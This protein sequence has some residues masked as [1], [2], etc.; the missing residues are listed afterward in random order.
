MSNQERKDNLPQLIKRAELT[1]NEL[2][3]RHNVPSFTFA[4]ESEFAMQALRANDYLAGVACKNQDSLKDA[5]I[6]VAAVGLS[7]SPVFKFAYLV[8][9]K[10]KVCLDISYT[11]LVELATAKGIILWC[12]AEIVYDTDV[13]DFKGVNELP[14]HHYDPFGERGKIIGGYVAAK[15]ANKDLL[16]DFMSI[17]EIHALRDRTESWKAHVKEG[18]STPWATDPHE[19]IKKTLIRRG[20]KSW[21][22]SFAHD[23]LAKAVSVSDEADGIDFNAPQ[24]TP[25]PKSQHREDGLEI[26]RGLLAEIGRTEEQYCKHLCRTT[27]RTI[28]ALEELTE[29]EITQAVAMLEGIAAQQTKK[30]L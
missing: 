24:L 27:K 16:V 14:H 19:M 9:R 13:F 30:A 11:G 15:L 10:G 26:L 7:L 22:K 2:A 23:V 21:P 29:T 20:Q 4:R 25:P 3:K 5:I 1:F 17:A 28:T 6:N 18:K 8:P 12:K